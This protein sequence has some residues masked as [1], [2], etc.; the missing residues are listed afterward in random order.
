VGLPP[1]PGYLFE[2]PASLGCVNHLVAVTAGCNPNSVTTNPS[3]GSNA[4]AVVD[5]YDY[6]TASG[7]LAAFDTQFGYGAPNFTVIYGTGN[8]NNGCVNGTKPSSDVSTGW[9]V[10]A[11]LDIEWSHAM[12]PSAH[13]YLVEAASSSTTDLFN[14]VAVAAKCVT[15]AGGG[16]VSMSFGFSEFSTEA[17]FD[18]TLTGSNVVFFASSGDYPGA[19]NPIS[20]AVFYPAASP[21][22]IGVGGTAYSRDAFTGSYQSQAV[23]ENEDLYTQSGETIVLGTGGGPSAYEP[24]PSYQARIATIVGTAR[25]T[26]DLT[27]L[28]DPATGVWVYNTPTFGGWNSV[29][30]TSLASPYTAGIFNE[31]GLFYPSSAAALNVIYANTAFLR[32]KSVNAVVSGNCGPPGQLTTGAYV[33]FGEPYSTQI[34]QTTGIPWSF[35]GGWGS[36]HGAH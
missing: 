26:P 25:G 3:G 10:E 22:A 20:P 13:L 6:A 12:A 34:Y 8:P 17:S 18:S 35:C 15:A 29:G 28:A 33:A 24:I 36:V 14:A 32:P 16:Q 30:G 27:G 11:A 2:T 1:F 31:L 21:N 19:G 5:A 9:D 23:W 4:I 7:D